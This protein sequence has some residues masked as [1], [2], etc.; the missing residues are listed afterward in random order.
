M[1]LLQLPAH[2]R[3]IIMCCFM[4]LYVFRC[5]T[6]SMMVQRRV[7]NVVQKQNEVVISFYVLLH[8][9]LDQYMQDTGHMQG[10]K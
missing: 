10:S 8:Q 6:D 7:N 9:R 3:M 4:G 1:L 2:L 5:D